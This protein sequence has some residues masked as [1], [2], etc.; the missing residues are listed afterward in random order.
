[1]EFLCED[2]PQYGLVLIPPSSP[3]YEP[4]LD[5]IQRQ[6]DHRTDGAPPIPEEFRPWISEQDRSTSAILFNHSP[7]TVVA[8]QTVW[9]FETVT[10]RTYRHSRGM[11]STQ[12]LLLPFG[13]SEDSMRLSGYWNTIFP[14]SKRYLSESG[15]AGDNSDVRLPAPDEKWGSRGI[16]FGRGGGGGG[17]GSRTS[18]RDI[19][20]QITLV[21]DGIFFED[22]LFAGPDGDKLFEQT[23]ATAEAYKLVG[24]IARDGHNHGLAPAQI[25]AEIEKATG[26][27][28]EHPTM[29]LGFHKPDATVD[30]FRQAALQQIA[31]QFAIRLKFPQ[32]IDDERTVYSMMRW[33]EAVLVHLR[34]G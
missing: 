5:G 21:L 20:K 9:R 25:L 23:V 15:M 11:L 1:V 12:D 6:M 10:G 14:G 19:V 4:L 32:L 28:P 34:K 16:I 13:R 22:G 33:T 24:K 17:G 30:E 7:K 27:A 29:N 2:L 18:G 3:D 26:P 31:F 8:L